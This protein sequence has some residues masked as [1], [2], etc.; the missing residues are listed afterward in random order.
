MA[1]ARAP[2]RESDLS[3]IGA[4]PGFGGTLDAVS[5]PA[6][7]IPARPAAVAA[8]GPDLASEEYACASEILLSAA[9]CRVRSD[10]IS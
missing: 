7:T 8:A 6:S 5:A 10:S 3:S 4:A 9:L 2:S 1:R